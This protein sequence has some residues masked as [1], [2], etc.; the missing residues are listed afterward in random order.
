MLVN[1]NDG[2][3]GCALCGKNNPMYGKNS[4]DYMDE[5]AKIERIKNLK[6]EKVKRVHGMA[7]HIHWR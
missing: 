5:D 4:W 7:G 6:K 2:G 1:I 3:D